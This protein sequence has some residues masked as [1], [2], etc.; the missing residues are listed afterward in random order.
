MKS[1]YKKIDISYL[2]LLVIFLSLISGLFKDIIMLFLVIII[3]ETGHIITSLYYGWKIK[4]ISISLCGGYIYYD[5]VIDKP[6]KEEFLIS[7]SGFL[8]QLLFLFITFILY[9]NNFLDG[10][11]FY[12]IKKYNTAVLLFNMLPIIP[13]D[14]SKIFNLFL[15]VFLSYKVSLKILNLISFFTLAI[16]ILCFL[17][18]NIQVECSYIMVF[19][20]LIKNILTSIKDIP[21]LF[22]RFLFE[23]YKCPITK[24]KYCYIKGYKLDKMKRQKKHLFLINDKAHSEKKVLSKKFDYLSIL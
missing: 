17:L 8:I 13:L 1:I 22:N 7:I 21:Y 18:L 16:I 5:E 11:D 9:K 19:S 4:K 14:G 15:N 23:R 10:K 24:G 12:L 3:H 6:F 20:F 2:F